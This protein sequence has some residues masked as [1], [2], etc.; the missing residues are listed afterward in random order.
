M[1][2]KITNLVRKYKNKHEQEI[3]FGRLT[4]RKGKK[5]FQYFIVCATVIT[6]GDMKGGLL[7]LIPK[8]RFVVRSLEKYLNYFIQINYLIQINTNLKSI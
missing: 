3:C 2:Q 8:G 7:L 4:N 5:S 6:F 1:P